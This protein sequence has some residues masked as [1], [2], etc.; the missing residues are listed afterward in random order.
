MPQFPID[1]EFDR[2]IPGISGTDDTP[3]PELDPLGQPV[4][5][6]DGSADFP[7]EPEDQVETQLF[8]DNLAEHFDKSDVDSLGFDLA[9]LVERD[10]K[11]REAR[12]KKY[13]EGLRRTGLGDDTPGGASFEGASKTVHPVLAES[14]IDFAG[15]A[16]KELFPPSGPVR[17]FIVGKQTDD[18][19]DKAERKKTYL[20]WQ[21]TEQMPEY[22]AELEELLTQLPM[23]GSQ[24]QKFWYDQRF[25]RPVSEFVPIDD[26]FL[27][28]SAT[29]FYTSPRVTHR[30]LITQ[31]TFEQR[32]DDGLYRDI[33]SA[34]TGSSYP[35]QSHSAEANDKIEGR[36]ADAYNED[37]LRAVLEIYI[38][39]EFDEDQVAQ[40][41]SAPYIVTV[42][43]YTEKVLA[44]YRNWEEGDPKMEK[45]DWLVEWKFIPWRGAYAIGFPHLIGSLAGSATGAL[46]ALLD[47]AHINNMPSGV[48][49]RGSKLNGQN[50]DIQ[51]TQIA[52]IEGPAGVDDIRKLVMGLP[53]NQP[54]PVL[55]QLLGWL[56]DAAKGVVA[57]ADDQLSQV[58]DRT[59]VGTTMALIEQGS[60]TYAAIHARL[61]YSQRKALKIICRLNKQ[62]LDEQEVIEELGE[63]II[64]QQDFV[65]NGDVIP[66]SDPSIFSESQRYAQQQGVLQMMQDQTVPWD[67]AEGYRRML[68]LMRI[69]NPEALLPTQPKPISRDPAEENMFVMTG[70]QP[71]AVFPDEDDLSHLRCHLGFMTNPLFGGNPVFAQG[72]LPNL[73]THVK[74]HI[75]QYYI[76]LVHTAA[77]VLSQGQQPGNAEQRDKLVEQANEQIAQ[78]LTSDLGPIMQAMQQAMQVM[79]ATAPKPPMDPATQVLLQTSMAEI[80]RK[81][82]ND[83]ATLEL[84]QKELL[85]IKPQI[86]KLTQQVELQKNT[87]DNVQ[88]Q[89]TDLQKNTQDNETRKLIEQ[90]REEAKKQ[91]E[92]QKHELEL[93]KTL[94]TVSTQNP[95]NDN[96]AMASALDNLANSQAQMLQFLSELTKSQGQQPT[97]IS[98]NMP[99]HTG[100]KVKTVQIKKAAD[101]SYQGVVVENQG[102]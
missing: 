50:I 25:K 80:D 24:Y 63:Q 44:I 55:F 71:I 12:D 36:E 56:T 87:Q 52:E 57:T 64:Y 20:N 61:H 66:V 82:Q 23:G 89:Q 83:Q 1:Q 14:C 93:V 101:G 75:A 85:E 6:P 13:E 97:N 48:K 53:F 74:D 10:K 34:A 28:Y 70:K 22:R 69:E 27:P 21:L 84:K 58:G 65:R 17:T 47:S 73:M 77:M 2:S 49:L 41:A 68:K 94:H 4:E 3:A 98:V 72:I 81:K 102:E 62:Y 19:L 79:Q 51:P 7:V 11:A 38:W 30:Q 45:L 99:D 92:D 8:Q 54:S 35:D 95:S 33:G 39:K 26:V 43:E 15:R 60:T 59:P 96:S 100:P 46:R 9:E 91:A 32:I 78:S 31:S 18:K 29:S 67:K 86:D 16:I 90:M 88:K 5:N 40:G 76:K 42:D 37:G